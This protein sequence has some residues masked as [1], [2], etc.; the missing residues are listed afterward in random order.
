[1]AIRISPFFINYSYYIDLF[2]VVEE[3]KVPINNKENAI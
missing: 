3:Q 1:M 2:P